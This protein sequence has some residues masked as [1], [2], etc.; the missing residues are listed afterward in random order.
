MKLSKRE[1]MERDVPWPRRFW[2]VWKTECLSWIFS[3]IAV[4]EVNIPILS[5]DDYVRHANRGISAKY[6]ADRLVV[7]NIF[8][9]L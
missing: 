6:C 9:K 3:I 1:K 7:L 2:K 4:S 5:G 8:V